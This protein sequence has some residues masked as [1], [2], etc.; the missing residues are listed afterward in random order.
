[1]EK[2]PSLI[3]CDNFIDTF[4]KNE[5]QFCYFSPYPS[6][7]IIIQIEK[8][9]EMLFFEI[10]KYIFD[11]SEPELKFTKRLQQDSIVSTTLTEKIKIWFILPGKKKN[12]I[13]II[14]NKFNIWRCIIDSKNRLMSF[15]LLI[16]NLDFSNFEYALNDFFYKIFPH[17]IFP[18]FIDEKLIGLVIFIEEECIIILDKVKSKN[19]NLFSFSCEK[20]YI[21]YDNGEIFIILFSIENGINIIKSTYRTY[22]SDFPFQIKKFDQNKFPIDMCVFNNCFY[23]IEK[24]KIIKYPHLNKIKGRKECKFDYD[25]IIAWINLDLSSEYFLIKENNYFSFKYTLLTT[26]DDKV[27]FKDIKVINKTHLKFNIEND[28]IKLL[29]LANCSFGLIYDNKSLLFWSKTHFT[30]KFKPSEIEIVINF[31]E[32]E[33]HDALESLK[34]M[35]GFGFNLEVIA[36]MFENALPQALRIRYPNKRKSFTRDDDLFILGHIYE[37]MTVKQISEKINHPKSSTYTRFLIN[38]GS[39]SCDDHFQFEDSCKLCQ[40]NLIEWKQETRQIILQKEY[41]IRE[42]SDSELCRMYSR[43]ERTIRSQTIHLRSKISPELYDNTVKFLAQIDCAGKTI[44]TLFLQCLKL[45]L[46]KKIEEIG[47]KNIKPSKFISMY[48]AIKPNMKLLKDLRYQYKKFTGKEPYFLMDKELLYLQGIN[49]ISQ[50]FEDF[51]IEK[52]KPLFIKVLK[53]I[54]SPKVGTL[55]ATLYLLFQFL[56]RKLTQ[57]QI[58]E[59]FNTTEVS[60]RSEVKKLAKNQKI[61]IILQKYIGPMNLIE[62]KTI[63]DLKR[64]EKLKL[65]KIK[66]EIEIKWINLDFEGISNL[67]SEL[68]IHYCNENLSIIMNSLKKLSKIEEKCVIHSLTEFLTKNKHFNDEIFNNLIIFLGSE[69]DL[70]IKDIFELIYFFKPRLKGANIYEILR[71]LTKKQNIEILE[72]IQK[73]KMRVLKHESINNFIQDNFSIFFEE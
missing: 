73:N 2:K 20:E 14:S 27:N 64:E 72:Y 3:V 37:D 11:P 38:Y 31:N 28:S 24:E 69:N 51:I 19:D 46:G 57:K 17:N 32:I 36:Q 58:A 29:K 18:Y 6:N 45:F 47:I 56:Y 65:Q 35:N 44:S 62:L 7:N 50:L 22:T 33:Q 25:I 52:I 40:K 9:G 68:E 26:T 63:S 23:V 59:V 60:L 34:I 71:N 66:R 1:M 55:P 70:I 13:I 30:R 21:S 10:N 41:K 16:K 39:P 67:L 49:S 53:T 4:L 61:S 12:E 42:Y 43:K 48:C 54:D 15:Q 8:Q 5:G